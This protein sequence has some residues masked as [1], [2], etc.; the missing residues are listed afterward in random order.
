L[1]RHALDHRHR[2]G[3][4]AEVMGTRSGQGKYSDQVCETDTYSKHRISPR[5]HDVCLS[6]ASIPKAAYGI[7]PTFSP[8]H[9]R[10]DT[11]SILINKQQRIEAHLWACAEAIFVAQLKI[12]CFRA[13]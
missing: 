12:N 6:G 13:E 1:T 10:H 5:P 3:P 4:G 2:F 7:M 8:A 11:T 9:P